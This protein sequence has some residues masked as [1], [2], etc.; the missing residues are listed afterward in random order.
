VQKA[1]IDRMSDEMA[2]AKKPKLEPQSL[3]VVT[4][5]CL[6]HIHTHWD[7]ELHQGTPKSL[8]SSAQRTVR[9][10][11]VVRTLRDLLPDVALLQEVD[12]HLIPREWQGG[13]L[14]C[15]ESLDGYVPYRSYGDR[16]EGTVVLLRKAVLQC[17]T[18]IPTAYLPK[19]SE[20]GWKTGVV[21]HAKR[22]AAGPHERPI[23]LASVHL[24]WGAPQQQS[25]LL[26]AAMGAR[27]PNVPM[28]LGGDFNAGVELLAA[29][30]IDAP[31][32]DAGLVRVPADAPTGLGSGGTIDH[33]YA[34]GV[35]LSPPEVGPLP[36]LPRGPW[37][38]GVPHNGSDHAWVRVRISLS[39]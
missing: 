6:A 33:L 29:E 23:A 39:V 11:T 5:N 38:E 15:G 16:G 22:V 10:R 13:P 37:T 12:E 26:A 30:R 2:T 18:S 7:T 14:P 35:R 32:L 20:H 24:R 27:A 1:A 28:V 21:V 17:D 4:W 8:E 9:L 25:A 36:P 34:A 3:T 19:T 31:L